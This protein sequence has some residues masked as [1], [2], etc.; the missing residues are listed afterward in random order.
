MNIPIN[1]QDLLYTNN[2]I[3]TDLLSQ[4]EINKNVKNYNNFRRRISRKD[5]EQ[6][7]FIE[8]STDNI[9]KIN[10]SQFP[11]KNN[12]NRY[13]I[14]SE[15]V[16]DIVEDKYK[17]IYKTNLYIYS[18]DRNKTLNLYPNN[19]NIEIPKLFNN[20]QKIVLKD[21]NI[22]NFLT[23]IN[24]TNN[25][26]CWQY[27]NLEVINFEKINYNIIPCIKSDGFVG[28]P[29]SNL[30]DSFSNEP[31]AKLTNKC[32]FKYSNPSL[33]DFN[34]YLNNEIN[35]NHKISIEE[36]Y[37]D[38]LVSNSN[39][40]GV[41][42]SLFYF[43]IDIDSGKIDVINRIEE[44]SIVAIQTF[45]KL[46]YNEIMNYDMFNN[47][48]KTSLSLSQLT[49]NSVYFI[50][51]YNGNYINHIQQTPGNP[52]VITDCPSIDGFD[53]HVLNMTELY[54]ANMYYDYMSTIKAKENL[55][56]IS[57]YKFVD[58]IEIGKTR[59]L[60]IQVN[61][62]TGNLNTNFYTERGNQIIP[63]N[64]QTIILN[65]SLK[66]FFEN[67]EINLNFRLIN[68]YLSPKIGRSLLFRFVNDTNILN[69]ND[70]SKFTIN[71]L[72][73]D[74]EYENV[75]ELKKSFLTSLLNW[76][77]NNTTDN[78]NVFDYDNNTVNFK[79]IHTNYDSVLYRV[80]D[81]VV[82][83]FDKSDYT[84]NE[85]Y[86]FYNKKL[87][88]VKKF[89]NI[90]KFENKHYFKMLPFI[91]VRVTFNKK[92]EALTGQHLRCV[93]SKK[94][95]NNISY[96]KYLNTLTY[97]DTYT[98]KDTNGI[99]A[100]INL[101]NIFGQPNNLFYNVNEEIV[102]YDKLFNKLDNI[103]IEYLT[104]DGK[105]LDNIFENSLT[106]E[107]YEEKEVLKETLINTKT[108]VIN[109]NGKSYF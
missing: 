108:G 38:E 13:P 42:K 41:M 15:T 93:E 36:P 69:S 17:K 19:Y 58:I 90:E 48:I 5:N 83:L 3:D 49:S 81:P 101:S 51:E 66:T 34:N 59:L 33:E 92:K 99:T 50:I 78:I 76:D 56:T 53:K 87:I 89:L 73:A 88:Q 44:L 68:D 32:Y 96:I 18:E 102:F 84:L 27:L 30:K 11:S 14:F 72:L 100:K 109:S 10:Q 65:N 82:K 28:I 37:K 8:D 43:D 47:Y 6:S 86:D 70:L 54:S 12:K 75:K 77:I 79:F 103:N 94:T 104:P 107:I 63:I 20:I 80:N 64:P 71:E 31:L 4:K 35:N 52:L 62:S 85:L 74:N 95:Q 22:S 105:I 29:Y 57:N 21:I 16:N 97:N 23:P 7:N 2:F 55:E 1:P 46:T 39:L 9:N 40:D 45:G 98:K 61:F 24:E 91:Y 26:L 106:L 25:I 67:G 60:R